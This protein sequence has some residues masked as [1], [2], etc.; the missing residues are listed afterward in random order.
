MKGSDVLSRARELGDFSDLPGIFH[1]CD[2]FET[3][4]SAYI[5]FD[6]PT[7]INMEKYLLTSGRIAEKDLI[8]MFRTLLV[9]LQKMQ[10]KLDVFNMCRLAENSFLNRLLYLPV[11][12]FVR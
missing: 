9:S 1:V 2:Q 11:L 3:D 6:Y 4:G 12:C 8:K 7:G 5:V 10:E